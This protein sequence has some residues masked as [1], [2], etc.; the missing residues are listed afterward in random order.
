[1]RN[2]AR[3][4]AKIICLSATAPDNLISDAANFMCLGNGYKT[5]SL[6]E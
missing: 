1:V 3:F 4:G 5:N 2:I 6:T